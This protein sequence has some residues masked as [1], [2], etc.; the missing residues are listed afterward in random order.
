MTAAPGDTRRMLVFMK[1]TP[2]TEVQLP[3]EQ[4]LTAMGEF[5]QQLVDA[6]IMVSGE[7]LHP[8]Q[9][10]ARIHFSGPGRRVER[11]PF[12]DA[13][14][15]VAGYWMWRVRSIDEA[16]DWA[17]RIPMGDAEAEVEIRPVFESADFG[18]AFTP[19]LQ[20]QEARI[21]AEAATRTGG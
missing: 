7:G 21:R 16:V 2:E 4:M 13:T 9:D 5:N 15:L 10:G 8:T 6:G 18:E 17:K 11:G 14:E 3:D 19:E 1:S 20:E 12:R